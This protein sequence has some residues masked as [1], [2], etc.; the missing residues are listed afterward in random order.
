MNH[1][2]INESK[3][4]CH[5]VHDIQ[6]FQHFLAIAV[7]PNLALLQNL[8]KFFASFFKDVKMQWPALFNFSFVKQ[9]PMFFGHLGYVGYFK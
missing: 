5:H 7:I 8:F 6:Y 3:C 1:I 2:L 9:P 4:L